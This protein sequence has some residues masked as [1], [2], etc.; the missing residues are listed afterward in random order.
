MVKILKSF[1]KR[2]IK[3]LV[4]DYAPALL[5]FLFAVFLIHFSRKALMAGA[6]ILHIYSNNYRAMVYEVVIAKREAYFY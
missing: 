6:D 3:S 2:L 5:T 1:F 4:S